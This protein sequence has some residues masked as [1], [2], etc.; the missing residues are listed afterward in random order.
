M[1][2]TFLVAEKQKSSEADKTY[3]RGPSISLTEMSSGIHTSEH[4]GGVGGVR[5]WEGSC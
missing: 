1:L 5:V 4:M 3:S 2:E